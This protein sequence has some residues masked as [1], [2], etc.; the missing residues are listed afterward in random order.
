MLLSLLCGWLFLLLL[1]SLCNYIFPSLIIW[2]F[3]LYRLFGKISLV[4][5]TI[6]NLIQCCFH[7][8]LYCLSLTI[9]WECS[10]LS[11]F[12][13]S[14]I[15]CTLLHHCDMTIKE[16]ILL[17]LFY[18]WIFSDIYGFFLLL[19]DWGSIKDG[20]WRRIGMGISL[21]REQRGTPANHFVQGLTDWV[22]IFMVGMV[23]MQVVGVLGVYQLVLGSW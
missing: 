15:L 4:Y 5:I 8:Y 12:S 20:Y 21:A 23:S 1:Y 9:P 18:V 11:P 2:K 22:R 14:L 16:I 17:L 19:L 7:L 6:S 13:F 3:N 10:S